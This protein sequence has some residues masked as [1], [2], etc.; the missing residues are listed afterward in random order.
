MSTGFNIN[1]ATNNPPLEP[2][3]LRLGF[4]SSSPEWPANWLGMKSQTPKPLWEWECVVQQDSHVVHRH[5]QGWKHWFGELLKVKVLVAQLCLTLC[6][7]VDC[8]PPGSS[9]YGISQARVLRGSCHSLL[10]GI[11]PTQG[12]NLGLLHPRQILYHLSYHMHLLFIPR[13]S[14]AIWWIVPED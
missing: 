5:F 6:D 3:L 4:P 7:P 11:F 1:N 14:P 9:A 13:D 10:Q 8:S 12:S 2:L